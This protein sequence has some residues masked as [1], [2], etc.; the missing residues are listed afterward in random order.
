MRRI[1]TLLVCFSGCLLFCGADWLQFRGSQSNS[2]APDAKAPIQWSEE[3]NIAWQVELPGRGPA[4]PIVVGDRVFVTCSS[5]Y[6]DNRMHILCFS[7]DDG[8]QLWHRQFW[9]TGRTISHPTTCIAAPTPASDGE[10]IYAFFASNDLVCL[11]LD[12]NLRWYRGLAYDY[13]KAGIDVGMSSSPVI[14]GDVVVVQIE[15]QGDSFA[16][17]I[18]RATGESIW[19]VQRPDIDNWSSPIAVKSDKG[20]I[21]LLQSPTGVTA[22]EAD[23]G[24]ELWTITET[25]NAITSSVAVDGRLFL[26]A[27]G[28]TAIDLAYAS[29]PTIAWSENRLNPGSASPVVHE[30]CLYIINRAGVLNC[31]SVDDGTL[32]WQTRLQGTMWATPVL[33]GEHLLCINQDG[34]AQAVHLG[35]E[36]EVVATSELG[37]T[38]QATPA[39]IDDALFIRSDNHLWKIAAP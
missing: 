22:L 4:S 13:P 23:S 2:V 16:A 35:E 8:S 33:V 27:G 9:A 11:D 39:V 25:C 19:R 14:A 1:I 3:E 6:H 28:I 31:G 38:I 20:D 36:G 32:L 26:P 29:A 12:G 37:E 34:L 15:N 24:E 7:T 21:V 18:D 30:G 5:G 10:A 17:G